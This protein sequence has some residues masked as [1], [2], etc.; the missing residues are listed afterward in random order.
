MSADEASLSEEDSGV[1]EFFG[2]ASDVGILVAG[3]AADVVGG[4]PVCG[5]P[6]ATAL[7]SRSCG[8][9]TS[10]GVLFP[11]RSCSGMLAG[12]Q[13]IRLEGPQCK[14]RWRRGSSH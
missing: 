2:D 1:E 5:A 11:E 7:P 12:D 14:G 9:G 3:C 8:L 13:E 10:S 4:G 6:P